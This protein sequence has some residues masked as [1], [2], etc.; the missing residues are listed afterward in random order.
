MILKI[1]GVH[2][3]SC[4]NVNLRIWLKAMILKTSKSSASQGAVNSQDDRATLG[5]CSQ[6]DNFM[7]FSVQREAPVTHFSFKSSKAA[8]ACHV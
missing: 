6:T 7:G 2:V 4:P 5:G 1:V 3:G 8:L